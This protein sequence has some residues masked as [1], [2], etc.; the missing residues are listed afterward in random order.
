MIDTRILPPEFTPL[1]EA[2]HEAMFSPRGKRTPILEITVTVRAVDM[3]K[4]L[5]KA[6]NLA[7]R[8]NES[9]PDD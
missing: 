8:L 2:W 9:T 5:N 7:V 3:E 1:L 6:C 4:A